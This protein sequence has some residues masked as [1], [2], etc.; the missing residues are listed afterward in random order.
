MMLFR[1]FTLVLVGFVASASVKGSQKD[2]ETEGGT[3]QL[4][5]A[6]RH[7]PLQIVPQ[8]WYENAIVAVSF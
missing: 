4:V 2:Q 8:S 5:R 6:G 1:V 7:G 3:Q